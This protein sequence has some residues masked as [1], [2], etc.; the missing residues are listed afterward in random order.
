VDPRPDASDGAA[1]RGGGETP[2]GSVLATTLVAALRRFVDAP[3]LLFARPD[4]DEVLTPAGGDPG[5][6]VAVYLADRRRP[7]AEAAA[8][9]VER[10]AARPGEG[11]VRC[12]LAVTSSEIY[13]PSHHHPGM[14]AEEP[15]V[16][17]PGVN[18]VAR[19]WWGFEAAVRQAAAAAGLPVVLLRA[20]PTPVRGGEDPFSALLSGRWARTW[21]GYDPVLQLLAVDDLAVALAA[22]ARWATARWAASGGVE[23]AGEFGAA[24]YNVVP[25]QPVPLAWALRLAGVRRL[26]LRASLRSPVTGSPEAD[27]LRYTWTAGGEAARRDLGFAARHT[28]AEVAAS[29]R[30]AASTAGAAGAVAAGV[31]SSPPRVDL[32]FDDFGLSLDYAAAQSRRVFGFLD[33][34]WWRVEQRG[35]ETLPRQGRAVMVGVHRGFM[36]FDGVLTMLRVRRHAGRAARFL[37]HPTLVKFPVLFNLMTRLGG[38]HACW[39]NAS[40]VL[41]R[42]GLLAVYPEGIRGAFTPYRRAYRLGKFGRREYVRMAL[43]HGAP[44][45]PFVTVGHA[46]IFPILGRLDW[47]WWKRFAEWPY[48]PLTPTFP[49]LPLPLPSKW[50]VW[51]L[52]PLHVEEEYPPQAADDPRAVREVGRRVEARMQQAI[53]DMLA[54]RRSLWWGSVF[55]ERGGSE[56]RGA[57]G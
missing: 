49:L 29:M 21:F 57:A 32:S 11:R 18:P 41:E 35:M 15:L 28:S 54:R 38:V 44:I 30:A 8:A 37:I 36:P 1:R 56:G 12:L 43:A 17:R 53:D 55:E 26:P 10:L 42:E 14:A 40:W 45:H 52:E 23:A 5:G 34:V 33:R 2:P 4:G 19:R 47:G 3:P 31:A 25:A 27:Y 16:L 46:E 13:E 50:H 22:A 24:V 20:A 48:L 51:F 6:A 39:E 7:D 9:A